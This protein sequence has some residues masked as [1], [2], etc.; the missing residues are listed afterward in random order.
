MSSGIIIDNDVV[1]KVCAYRHHGEMLA[2]FNVG[3]LSVSILN[4]ARFTIRSHLA[5]PGRIIDRASTA[6]AF[7]E[8]LNYVELLEPTSE[9][10]ELAAELE[11]RASSAALDFDTGESQLVAI[12]ISRAAA[13]LVTGDKRA[14]VA[15]AGIALH[16]VTGRVA[17]LEQLVTVLLAGERYAGLRECVCA[18]PHA[19]RAVTNCFAC[20]NA[21]VTVEDI[22]D[23]LSSYISH[24][25]RETN[26]FLIPNEQLFTIVS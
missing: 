8:L 2:A 25:R 9:E 13:L 20:R 24:L 5:R 1:L 17:C 18:E 3:G 21:S 7:E 15:L 19:D 16:E 14:I 26:G 23:G 10:I 4:I 6:A 12:L 22:F 11:E